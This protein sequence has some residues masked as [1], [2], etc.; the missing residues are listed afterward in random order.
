MFSQKH[1]KNKYCV[2]INYFDKIE[3]YLLAQTK[4]CSPTCQSFKCAKTLFSDA[5]PF[6]AETAMNP[7]A[8]QNARTL[9]ALK[10]VMLPGAICGET[11]K[12]KTV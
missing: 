8:S 9:C 4:A 1:K 5:I 6:G 12:R 2:N 10:G 11:V 3:V 7:V